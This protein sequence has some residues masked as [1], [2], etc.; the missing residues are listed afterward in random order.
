[1]SV[2]FQ[3]QMENVVRT[4]NARFEQLFY[5]VDAHVGRSIR[6]GSPITGAAGQPVKSGALL[7]SWI[8]QRRGRWTTGWVSHSPYAHVI[9]YN[10]RGA[11][12]HSAVG[13]F[14]SVTMTRAGFRALVKYENSRVRSVRFDPAVG[15]WRN[16]QG[17]FAKAF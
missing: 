13:G 1:M 10:L 3:R 4:I 14:Y 11:Q 15:R 6:I 8:R 7:A 5:N 16:T 17:Q 9:E 2:S 12:L